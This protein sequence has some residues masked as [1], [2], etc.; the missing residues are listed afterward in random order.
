[1]MI[2]SNDSSAKYAETGMMWRNI[3]HGEQGKQ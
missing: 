2:I 1:M 3:E